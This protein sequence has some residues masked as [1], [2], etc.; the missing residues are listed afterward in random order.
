MVRAEVI[1]APKTQFSLIIL[2]RT[3][4]EE[5]LKPAGAHPLPCPGPIMGS[6]GEVG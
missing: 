3:E 1:Q 2:T 4:L 6:L 5:D